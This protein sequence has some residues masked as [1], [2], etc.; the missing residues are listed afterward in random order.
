LLAP[1]DP[2]RPAPWLTFRRRRQPLARILLEKQNPL[3]MQLVTPSLD[4]SPVDVDVLD[5]PSLVPTPLMP[6]L[7]ECFN[8]EDEINHMARDGTT[9]HNLEIHAVILWIIFASEWLVMIVD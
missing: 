6:Q 8:V 9:L 3:L 7:T 5:A 2:A 1:I 4:G